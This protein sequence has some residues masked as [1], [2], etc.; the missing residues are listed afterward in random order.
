VS[1]KESPPR[2]EADDRTGWVRPLREVCAGLGIALAVVLATPWIEP[3]SDEAGW[4]RWLRVVAD[5]PVRCGL[6]ATLL[7]F[8]L[9]PTKRRRD[10]SGASAEVRE[11][12][13]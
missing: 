4:L 8:A 11:P 7:A 12:P 10:R 6:A 2:V 13:A 1:A 9:L 5:H 3:S